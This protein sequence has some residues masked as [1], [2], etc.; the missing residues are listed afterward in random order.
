MKTFKCVH[1][2]RLSIEHDGD[3]FMIEV[4]EPD[5][6]AGPRGNRMFCYLENSKARKLAKYILKRIK[7]HNND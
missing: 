6:G 7:E 4:F 3:D 2:D 5:L 1:K